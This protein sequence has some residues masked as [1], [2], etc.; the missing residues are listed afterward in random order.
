[1]TTG[2][3]NYSSQATY[4]EKSEKF[5]ILEELSISGVNQP[6]LILTGNSDPIRLVVRNMLAL[7]LIEY[8]VTVKKVIIK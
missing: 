2:S 4:L 6:T 5:L 3:S 1:M 7:S 8:L